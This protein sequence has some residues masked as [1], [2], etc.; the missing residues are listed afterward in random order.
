MMRRDMLMMTMH[1]D[2]V[3]ARQRARRR[4]S[5]AALVL[6]AALAIAVPLRGVASDTHC[7]GLAP[8]C[9]I[10]Q[11]SVCLCT[12]PDWN[13]CTWRCVEKTRWAVSP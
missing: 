1:R 5:V 8:S 2:V 7:P 12:T 4:G 6:V 11:A 9:H 10:R 13:S 3:R